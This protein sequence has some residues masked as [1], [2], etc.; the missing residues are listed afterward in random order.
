MCYCVCFE[1]N[2]KF[3]SGNLFHWICDSYQIRNIIIPHIENEILSVLCSYFS[4]IQKNSIIFMSVY[5]LI[6]CI[7]RCINQLFKLIKCKKNCVV[8]LY[9]RYKIRHP[10]IAVSSCNDSYKAN[11][12]LSLLLWLIKFI[13]S[14]S[15]FTIIKIL[16]NCYEKNYFFL[17]ENIDCYSY[18]NTKMF[19]SCIEKF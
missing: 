15:F 11:I 5:L 13:I 12:N 1:H 16:D 7:F 10:T 3:H 6:Y 8:K 14:D 17:K 2:D 4:I 9:T 19:N 18:R